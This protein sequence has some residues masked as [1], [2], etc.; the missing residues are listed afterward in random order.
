MKK[1]DYRHRV[2]HLGH[3]F[4]ILTFYGFDAP[5]IRRIKK[6]GTG[7]ATADGRSQREYVKREDE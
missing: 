4:K 5:T 7:H 6:D 3:Y 2:H 1:A